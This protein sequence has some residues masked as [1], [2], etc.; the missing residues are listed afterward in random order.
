M[1]TA[2]ITVVAGR[3][4]HLTRQQQGLAAATLRP[5]QRVI[6]AI[7]D[8]IAA[9]VHGADPTPVVIAHPRSPLGL[10]LAAARNAGAKR[11]IAGGADLLIFLDVDCIPG[12]DLILRY[13]Q[14]APAGKRTL[15]CGPVAYLPPAP[16][17][18]YPPTGLDRLAAPHPARPAPAD[19]NTLDSAEHELF[20]S[21]SFALTTEVWQEIGG[22]TEDYV[23]YGGED[24]D[25]GQSARAHGIGLRWIGGATAFHQHHPVSDPPY[26][27]LADILRN[28]AIFH[29]RWGWWPMTGWLTK[30]ERLGLAHHDAAAATWT[31]RRPCPCPPDTPPPPAE[32]LPR[33]L[34][35][36]RLVDTDTGNL[37]YG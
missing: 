36:D 17:G 29:R 33:V 4:T 25:F 6:V 18:G 22:F 37:G 26:E 31:A 27:H 30:F 20:W 15:L 1:R 24:T 2:V 5:D 19:G 34:H 8:D 10:P 32:Q 16:P 3:H 12:P 35:V 11:A 28:A 7:D 13:K 21:L 9:A 23:G 14:A